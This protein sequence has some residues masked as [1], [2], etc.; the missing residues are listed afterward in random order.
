MPDLDIHAVKFDPDEMQVVMLN[1]VLIRFPAQ[2]TLRE[3][4]LGLDY[5]PDDF[6]Q[7]DA[8]RTAVSELV[9]AGLLRLRA[10][11]IAPTRAALRANELWGIVVG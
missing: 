11:A 5:D 2:L 3:L 9:A 7:S 6:A 1:E 8:I 4:T 10:E